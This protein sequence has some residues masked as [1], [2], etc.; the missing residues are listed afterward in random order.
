MKREANVAL[1]L[2]AH[3]RMDD[4]MDVLLVALLKTSLTTFVSILKNFKHNKMG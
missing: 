2:D 3:F 1:G 4:L